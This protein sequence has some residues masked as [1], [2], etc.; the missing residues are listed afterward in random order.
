MKHI[1]NLLVAS[2]CLT[3]SA[4][5]Q[6]PGWHQVPA[7]ALNKKG[8]EIIRNLLISTDENQMLEIIKPTT[9]GDDFLRI[10]IFAYKRLGMY[11]TKAAVPV[12]IEK[13][14]IPKEGFYARYALETIPD[15]GVDKALCENV[16][17]VD[18]PEL[19]A[20]ILTTLGVRANPES[21]ATAKSF[22]THKN[23]DVKQA[24]AYAYASTA[25]NG[26][27][28][29]FA[30]KSLDPIFADS[31]FLLAE[32]LL[33]KGKTSAALRIYDNLAFAKVKPYQREAALYQRILARGDQG[34]NLLLE[35]LK[36]DSLENYEV[37]LKVGRE[38]PAS[39]SVTKAMVDLLGKQT[40]L[41]RKALLIRS[42][43]DR[44]DAAVRTI[45]LPVILELAKSGDESVRIAAIESFRKIG[46]SSVVPILLDIV[47]R[48]ESAKLADVSRVTLQNLS[49]KDIDVAIGNLVAD[50]DV[51][52][53]I[54]AIELVKDRRI[55]SAYP[56]LKKSI[57]DSNAEVRKASFD[58]IGQ[59]AGLVDL[60]LI[61]DLFAKTQAKDETDKLLIALKSICTRLP[62]DAASEEVRKVFEKSP[63]SVKLNLLELLREIGGAKAV[64]IVERSAFEDVE[65]VQNKATEVLGKW[66]SQGDV[67]LIAAACL[68]VAKESKYKSRGLRGYIR[69]AR[70]FAMS[71]E[72]K[73]QICQETYDLAT[74]DDDKILIFGVYERNPTLNTFNVAAKYL[75]ND[76]EKLRDKAAETLVVIGEK[77][78]VKSPTIA[79]AMKKVIEQSKNEKLKERAKRI[80]DKQ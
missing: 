8:A 72:R 76:N 25:G 30:K 6:D 77:L 79:D 31:A 4:F 40:D 10:K 69:L 46:D 44:K 12:L 2:I 52:V 74:Q 20:G 17:K 53:R 28:D 32:N 21:A 19:I 22:L 67:D 68:K 45:A 75:D 41:S 3:C 15:K 35:L 58:A 64:S 50:E 33:K 71:E 38:L 13:L 39:K 57:T 26:A 62:Q 1:F 55:V 42:I 36:A 65:D 5:A 56:L 48:R 11:G 78:Q 51:S 9:E 66:T 47:K 14:E 70:Q 63:A 54:L 43:S 29:F 23:T 49:G 7:D 34:V 60:P 16:K 27:I 37:G 61:L 18:K 24:A 73:L 80:F 59:T